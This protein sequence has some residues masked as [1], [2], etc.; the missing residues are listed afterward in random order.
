MNP[1]TSGNR[2]VIELWGREFNIVKSGLSEA[3]VV[4]FVNDLAKQ[5]D[6]LLQRQ[7]HLAALTKLAERTVSEADKLAEEMK[8]EART[9][10]NAEAARI[11]D[12]TAARAKSEAASEIGRASCRE[13]V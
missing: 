13:R 9:Q 12:E 2:D 4:S 8:E 1:N 3:Q 10:A 11:V 5:H 6:V 7:E